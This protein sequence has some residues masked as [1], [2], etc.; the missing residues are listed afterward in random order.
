MK[1]NVNTVLA[2]LAGT[3]LK[4][5]QG[6]VTFGRVFVD[7]LLGVSDRDRNLTGAKKLERARLAEKLHR[8]AEGSG[9]VD[10]TVAEAVEIKELVGQ[11]GT[12]IVVLNVERF[13]EG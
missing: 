11:V 10:I 9:E 6:D 2:N 4:D 13:I 12:P 5:E 7:F 8:A 3:P 1:L